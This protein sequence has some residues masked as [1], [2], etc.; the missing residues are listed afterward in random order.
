MDIDMIFLLIMIL[1]ML[2][3]LQIFTNTQWKNIILNNNQIK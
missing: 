3:I 2:V 1:L